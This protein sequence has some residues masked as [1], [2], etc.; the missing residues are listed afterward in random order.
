I[1]TEGNTYRLGSKNIVNDPDAD[2]GESSI[3]LTKNEILISKIAIED[4]IRPEALGLIKTLKSLNI[5]P[6]LLSGDLKSKCETIASILG[7]EE[8]HA[9][10][11]PHQKL[12][13]IEKIKLRGKTA[14][15]GD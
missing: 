7:I 2:L 15:V 14:M 6:V 11:L 12:E 3:F 13:I 1:D 9:E 10:T 5:T 4:K 8:V